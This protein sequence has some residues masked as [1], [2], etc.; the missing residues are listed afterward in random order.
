VSSK[1]DPDEIRRKKVCALC[2]QDKFLRKE[3]RRD[4]KRAKC[5]YC[6]RRNK[7]MK[8]DDFAGYIEQAFEDHYE[9]TSDDHPYDERPGEPVSWVIQEAAL[10]DEP[11]A[12]DVRVVLEDQSGVGHDK[13]TMYS[14]NPF[15]EEAHYQGKGV[16]VS[17]YYE[18]WEQF[19]KSILTEARLFNRQA[20]VILD[21]IFEGLEAHATAQGQKL[22]V[23]AGPGKKISAIYRARAF[24][25]DQKLE[26]AIGR[27]DIELGPPPSTHAVAG[28]M[29]SK[30]I[31]VFY[32]ATHPGVA[33]AE[34]RPPVGS[35][36]L[37]GRF[38]IIRPLRLLDLDAMQSI[39]AKGS[40]FERSFVHAME[41]SA[42]LHI[43]SENL[44]RPVMPDDEA[45]EYLVTQ[46][47]ADYLATRKEPVLDG[48]IYPSAQQRGKLK[49][50]VVLFH[51]SARVEDLGLPRHTKINAHVY[52][53]DED[54]IRPDYWV[55][56][57]V[58]PKKEKVKKAGP[59][60]LPDIFSKYP[61][62]R[63]DS[64]EPALRIELPSLKVK[65]VESV[66]F[67]SDDFSITRNEYEMSK[68]ELEKIQKQEAEEIPF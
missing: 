43:L 50:N 51:K 32:G 41:K 10:I 20:E 5:S 31:G 54:G 1:N 18:E 25:S 14:E 47:I 37:V 19:R 16:R 35:R 59:D 12:E 3:I 65:H 64:R 61:D 55:A 13:D 57:T 17:E 44:T 2:T 49:R 68:A 8:I 26:A 29:N 53:Q 15:S 27:P 7:A 63:L 33:L 67:E 48:I 23:D 40:I 11:V 60:W 38:H 34:I 58:P 36:V 46:A 39:K 62:P 4:G 21:E 56:V 66:K 45:S 9:Q 24:Q 28:R 52:E 42:F 6:G 22:I 30:G